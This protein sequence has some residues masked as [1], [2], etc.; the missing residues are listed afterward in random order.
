MTTRKGAEERELSDPDR[1]ERS[2]MNAWT[3]RKLR[4]DLV[5]QLDRAVPQRGGRARAAE[6]GLAGEVKGRNKKGLSLRRK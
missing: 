4:R 5:D 2:N 1:T 6:E 3:V